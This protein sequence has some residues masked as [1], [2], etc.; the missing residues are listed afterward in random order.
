M[1]NVVLPLS[2]KGVPFI[3]VER[4]CASL[5]LILHLEEHALKLDFSSI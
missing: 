5:L 1:R 4:L 3:P 2:P